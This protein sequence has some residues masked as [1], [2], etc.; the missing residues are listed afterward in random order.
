MSEGLSD[1]TPRGLLKFNIEL[2]II[3]TTVVLFSWGRKCKSSANSK[4][5]QVVSDVTELITLC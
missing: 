4:W 1:I 5:G 2:K 3:F